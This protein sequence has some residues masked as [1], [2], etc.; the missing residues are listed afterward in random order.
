MT[1]NV[2]ELDVAVAV[3][4]VALN[5]T[6]SEPVKLAAG[7]KVTMPVILLIETAIFVVEEATKPSVSPESTSLK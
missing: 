6:D 5:V 2:T 7:V 1:F 4:S 3:P